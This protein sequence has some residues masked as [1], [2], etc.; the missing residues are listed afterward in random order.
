MDVCREAMVLDTFQ[1]LVVPN[2]AYDFQI[3][4]HNHYTDEMPEFALLRY[5]I[6]DAVFIVRKGLWLHSRGRKF[7]IRSAMY[8]EQDFYTTVDW[9]DNDELGFDEEL[10]WT[11]CE[12]C[13]ILGLDPDEV[14][15]RAHDY[16]SVPIE[17]YT[18]RR[19]AVPAG[20]RP[21]LRQR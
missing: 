5:M 8:T 1:H 16:K 12:V 10:G 17:V 11:F 20:R 18:Q 19:D 4:K 21:K 7:P 2:I 9:M 14:R 6:D 3:E 15:K 13:S